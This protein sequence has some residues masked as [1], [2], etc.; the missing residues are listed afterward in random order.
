MV[1]HGDGFDAGQD[2]VLGH[3]GSQPS[4][5][6][7]QHTGGSQPAANDHSNLQQTIIATCSTREARN[8]QQTII[9]TCSKRS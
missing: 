4:H 8:L 6:H 2:N 5:T 9:A 3:L 1:E 7:Q